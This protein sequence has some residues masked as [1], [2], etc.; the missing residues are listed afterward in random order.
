LYFGLGRS[1]ECLA[2]H[3]AA[4]AHAQAAG[5]I[6]AEANALSGLGDANYLRGRIATAHERFSACVELAHRNGLGRIEVANRHMAAWTLHFLGALEKAIAAML[7]SVDMASRVSAQRTEILARTAIAYIQGWLMGELVPARAQLETSMALS[8]ALG[9][10]R[11]E[12]QNLIF[13]ALLLLRSGEREQAQAAARDALA[14]CRR[15]GMSFIGPTALGTLAQVSTDPQER[16]D[17]LAEGEDL[18]AKGSISH[19]YFD[20]YACAIDACLDAGEH[21]AM[22]R[23]CDAFERYTAAEPVLWSRLAVGRGRVLARTACG[24]RSEELLMAIKRLRA[25]TAQAGF[26]VWVPALDAAIMRIEE[27]SRA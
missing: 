16:R 17:A 23:Y 3:E 5:S 11:F 2:E 8:R 18:L 9:A 21:A 1:A 4:L 12:S 26:A 7:E 14:F 13:G 19:N 6:E 10:K 24:E 25:E 20:F 27:G 22:S 15:H